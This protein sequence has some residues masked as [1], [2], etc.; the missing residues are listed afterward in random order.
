[1]ELLKDLDGI[2][3]TVST[4][5]VLIELD[6]MLNQPPGKVQTTKT[7]TTGI[8]TT[9]QIP[10][11][12]LIS[13]TLDTITTGDHKMFQHSMKD[14][15]WMPRNTTLKTEPSQAIPIF[16]Q[17]QWSIGTF[18]LLHHHK[19]G[20]HLNNGCNH[21]NNGCHHHHQLQ[22]HTFILRLHHPQSQ[23][24]WWTHGH[25]NH[26]TGSHGMSNMELATTAKFTWRKMEM[27]PPLCPLK[28]KRRS[29]TC[30]LPSSLLPLLSFSS[31]QESA[32]ASG[33][34]ALPMTPNNI[35]NTSKW[36]TTNPHHKPPDLWW[37]N[38]MTMNN[39][40]VK[41]CKLIRVI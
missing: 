26:R 27:V 4:M 15:Q 1:M 13:G 12:A 23:T 22:H 25:I 41:F 8:T 6:T 10:T 30:Q 37:E 39:D 32:W 14:Y 9:G 19:L 40:Q 3:T 29:T 5:M 31:F 20:S 36:E 21:L 24:T 11:Q 2:V 34:R 35:D 7:H 33:T 38:L 18:L 28:P 16:H 17:T